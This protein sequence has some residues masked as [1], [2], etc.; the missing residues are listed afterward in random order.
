MQR[1]ARSDL[2]R[3]R[4]SPGAG[5]TLI[6][7][8]VALALM[9]TV[10]LLSWRGLDQV[11]RARV[12]LSRVMDRERA[13]S[14]LFDQMHS[15]LQLTVRDEDI[16]LPPIRFGSDGL[17][18]IRTLHVPGQATRLQVIRYRLDAGHIVRYASAA[19]ANVG[20]LRAAAA[21]SDMTQWTSIV[22]A[23]DVGGFQMRLY[24]PQNGWV[25][26]WQGAQNAIYIKLNTLPLPGSGG[27]GPSPRDI[28]GVELEIHLAGQSG[29]LTRIFLVGQ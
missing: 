29:P 13:L 24:V 1:P 20:Q 12:T 19:L 9:A 23:G 25:D 10:A 26:D 5:F 17:Q 28:T 14:M 3:L 15:D 8:M 16:G 7:L 4:V 27:E 18:L 22:L 2:C 6:E 11:A 21:G